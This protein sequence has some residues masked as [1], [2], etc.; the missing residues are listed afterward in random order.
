VDVGHGAERSEDGVDGLASLA[1]LG[2]RDAV[3]PAPTPDRLEA[4]LPRVS[5]CPLELMLQRGR[6]RS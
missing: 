5:L 4:D 2:R 1:E 6:N 3:A